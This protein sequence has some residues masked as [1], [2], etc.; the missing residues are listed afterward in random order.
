MRQITDI[1]QANVRYLLI[2]WGKYV[3][4]RVDSGYPS[5]SPIRSMMTTGVTTGV[6]NWSMELGDP[7]SAEVSA[8]DAI[9]VQ[10]EIPKR[11][12]LKAHYSDHGKVASKAKRLNLSVGTY[13]TRLK[14]AENEV[15]SGLRVAQ[16]E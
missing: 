6:V 7:V 11:Q 3:R 2:Q 15:M 8:V 16:P 13:Y 12:I 4:V 5:Q 14:A 10:L 1:D 9:I